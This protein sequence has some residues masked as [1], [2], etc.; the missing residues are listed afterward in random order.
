MTGPQIHRS[1][2]MLL[3]LVMAVIG[4]ALLVQALGGRGSALSPRLL[5]G[6]LF[7]AAG[8]GRIYVEARRGHRT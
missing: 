7:L 4:V 5:A 6:V 1:G 8:V 2:T 3:S